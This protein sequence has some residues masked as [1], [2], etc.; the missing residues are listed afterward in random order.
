MFS[1]LS[2]HILMESVVCWLIDQFH[3]SQIPFSLQSIGHNIGQTIN[4]YSL[5]SVRFNCQ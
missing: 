4:T 2:Q 5:E 3:H 1:K